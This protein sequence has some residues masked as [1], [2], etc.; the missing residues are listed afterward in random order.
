M[1]LDN[2]PD[3]PD[4]W[5]EIAL[6]RFN[7]ITGF[8]SPELICKQDTAKE[9]IEI[10]RRDEPNEIFMLSLYQ[11]RKAPESENARARIRL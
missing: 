8:W 3:K 10:F 5:K 7:K 6:W 1:I 9:W 11:P 2:K 4:L